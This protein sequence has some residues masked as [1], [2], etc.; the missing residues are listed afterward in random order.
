M[1]GYNM[2][3]TTKIPCGSSLLTLCAV[4]WYSAPNHI[5]IHAVFTYIR[6]IAT[7]P[8]QA[9]CARSRNYKA[10]KENEK[11]KKIHLPHVCLGAA[12][13]SLMHLLPFIVFPSPPYRPKS[14]YLNMPAES[15]AAAA[16]AS[17]S[18][19]NQPNRTELVFHRHACGLVF[20]GI[21]APRDFSGPQNREVGKVLRYAC[22]L[23]PCLPLISKGICM[24]EVSGLKCG[25]VLGKSLSQLA[26]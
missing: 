9:A 20:W 11:K 19:A 24:L 10:L 12:Q 3:T 7:Y 26:S 13:T 2:V 18:S 4:L 21:I 14:S 25:V 15:S 8:Q 17:K 16:A 23:Q 5:H 1:N 6:H 22:T